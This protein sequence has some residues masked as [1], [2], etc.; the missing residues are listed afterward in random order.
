MAASATG[1][2]SPDKSR[3][4]SVTGNHGSVTGIQNKSVTVGMEKRVSTEVQLG[5]GFMVY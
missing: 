3:G 5:H 4:R 2:Q 1:A